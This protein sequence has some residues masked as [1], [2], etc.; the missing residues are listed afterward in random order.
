VLDVTV[1]YYQR[2]KSWPEQRKSRHIL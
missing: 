2:I 1:F